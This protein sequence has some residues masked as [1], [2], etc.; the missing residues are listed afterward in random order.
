M[1]RDTESKKQ[2]WAKDFVQM[3][4][5]GSPQHKNREEKEKANR[6]K[7]LNAKKRRQE[8][9]EAYRRKGILNL[10]KNSLLKMATQKEKR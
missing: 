3:N 10:N 4:I 8:M 7:Q 6:E 5:G 9:V 1:A 2:A